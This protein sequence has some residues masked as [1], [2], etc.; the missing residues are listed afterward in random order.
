MHKPQTFTITGGPAPAEITI[1]DPDGR[2]V[3]AHYTGL[4]IRG[5]RGGL[6]EVE[7][8]A[9]AAPVDLKAEARP[10][11]EIGSAVRDRVTRF[12]GTVV[13]RAVYM[14]G[15]ARCLVAATWG[16]ATGGRL[17]EEWFDESRL[18]INDEQA[19]Q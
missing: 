15:E 19:A 12:V 3:T 18:E 16:E 14:R 7:L 11:I 5:D 17:S 10:A 6:L 2:D 13:A 8:R 9:L 4:T 1:T